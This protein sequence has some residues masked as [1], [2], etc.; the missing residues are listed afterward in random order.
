MLSRS[1]ANWREC[2]RIR[3]QTDC[4]SESGCIWAHNIERG[5]CFEKRSAEGEAL[6][7]LE[8]AAD[9]PNFH[10]QLPNAKD[11]ANI[12]VHSGSSSGSTRPNLRG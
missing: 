10:H 11:S 1:S 8:A 12:H 2:E 5:T 7:S 6:L 4:E 9:D 3:K